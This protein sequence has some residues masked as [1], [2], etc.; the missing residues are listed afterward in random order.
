MRLAWE[1][2]RLNPYRGWATSLRLAWKA[3][4]QTSLPQREVGKA[5]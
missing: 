3:L 5:K 2:R 1:Y 4:K